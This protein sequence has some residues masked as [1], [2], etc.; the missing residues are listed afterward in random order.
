L[1]VERG[2]AMGP[3]ASDIVSSEGMYQYEQIE[4][5]V[6]GD[7]DGDGDERESERTSVALGRQRRRENEMDQNI[8]PVDAINNL[9]ER[10]VVA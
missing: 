6:Q 2:D 5:E 10:S 1:T 4:C 9:L 8:L 3:P 7:G